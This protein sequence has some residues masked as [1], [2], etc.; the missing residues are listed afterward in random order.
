[1][2]LTVDSEPHYL[3]EEKMNLVCHFDKVD[4]PDEEV[5]KWASHHER[6]YKEVCFVN[7]SVTL[8]GQGSA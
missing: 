5:T 1:M 6:S 8:E 4:E 3:F 2:E 7:D